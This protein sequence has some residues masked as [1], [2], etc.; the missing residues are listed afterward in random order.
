VEGALRISRFS[1]GSVLA[2]V[3]LVTATS[4]L[5]LVREWSEPHSTVR[6]RAVPRPDLTDDVLGPLRH[7]ESLDWYEGEWKWEAG[8]VGFSLAVGKY[9]D[10]TPA[11]DR[12]RAVLRALASH[13]RAA[14][15]YAVSKLLDLK[16]ENWLEEDEKPV[17]AEDFKGCMT[18]ESV[19]FEADGDVTFY[20]HDGDLFWGHWIEIGMDV[21]D[22]FHHADIPG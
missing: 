16:N 3:V 12:A 4:L 22:V 18:L 1:L 21:H 17:T 14:K 19:R 15:D 20:F 2:A 9:K 8:V 13:S 5:G 7:D 11:R 6:A 10:V